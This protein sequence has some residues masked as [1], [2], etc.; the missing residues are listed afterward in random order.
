MSPRLSRSVAQVVG[1]EAV[2]RDDPVFVL[3]EAEPL[4]AAPVVLG[5]EQH[6]EVFLVP[7]PY[8]AVVLV[9]LEPPG[10]TIV[11]DSAKRMP[12]SV[13]RPTTPTTKSG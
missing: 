9:R 13:L 7:R 6:V 5:H 3:G 4:K 2:L 1:Q 11:L 10:F 12:S 8:L